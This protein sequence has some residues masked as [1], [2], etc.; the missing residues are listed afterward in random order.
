M[1]PPEPRLDHR[2][3]I[4]TLTNS[5]VNDLVAASKPYQPTT[6]ERDTIARQKARIEGLRASVDGVE[7]I[8]AAEARLRLV[9][10]FGNHLKVQ[11]LRHKDELSAARAEERQPLEIELAEA[12]GYVGLQA[13][14]S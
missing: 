13:L 10:R 14:R 3:T 12:K 1:A 9:H 2:A 7:N 6:Y 4:H 11:D 5:D 8:D